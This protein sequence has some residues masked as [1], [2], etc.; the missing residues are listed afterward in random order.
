MI[1]RLARSL[2]AALPGLQGE[3][4]AEALWLAAKYPAAFG[5]STSPADVIGERTSQT[6][7]EALEAPADT[8]AET[9][10]NINLA[11]TDEERSPQESEAVSVTEVG[12][13]LLPANG[14]LQT[15]VTALSQFRRVRRPGPQV[16]DV[17]ATIE[18]TADAG[19]LVIVTG[20]SQERGLDVVIVVDRTPVAMVWTDTI[21]EFAA[22]LRRTG[23]F[24]SVACW[25]LDGLTLR[26]SAGT[27]HSSDFI[28]DP[29]GRRLVL[30]LTD[31]T[32]TWWY[33]DQPWHVL[34]RWAKAMPT[35]LVHL[36]PRS[37]WGY[38][39]T[40]QPSAT[41]RSHHPASPNSSAKVMTYWWSDD[42]GTAD[43]AVPIIT[44]SQDDIARWVDAVVSGSDWVD[45]VWVRPPEPIAAPGTKLSA[46]DQVSTFQ[47]RASVG[48]QHL[49]RILAGAPLL[50]LQ[51]IRALHDQLVPAPEVGQLAEI[52]VSGLLERLPEDPDSTTPLLRF[53]PGVADLLYKGT[54]ASQEWD[55]Y[56]MLTQH[57][58]RNART[59]N[60]IRA[61][62]ADPHGTRFIDGDLVPFAAMGRG[63]AI[64]LGIATPPDEVPTLRKATAVPVKP[65]DAKSAA[66]PVVRGTS[67][68]VC[69]PDATS[70][71]SAKQIADGIVRDLISGLLDVRDTDAARTIEDK[72]ISVALFVDLF[73]PNDVDQ[74]YTYFN[75]ADVRRAARERLEAVITDDTRVIVTNSFGA[76]VAYELL[77]AHPEWPLRTLVTFNAPLGSPPV[78]DRLD[79]SPR[80]SRNL[81]DRWPESITSWTNIMIRGD[82]AAAGYDL[83]ELF[84]GE[85]R[86]ILL[87]DVQPD[88]T[89]HLQSPRVASVIS[90]AL[91]S[92]QT[93]AASA[94]AR[95]SNSRRYLITCVVDYTTSSFPA[96]PHA[97]D[98]SAELVAFFRSLDYEHVS[99]APADQTRSR[100]LG[101]LHRFI[102]DPGRQP[103]D[104]VVF[105]LSGHA[106]VS[107]GKY[108]FFPADATPGQVDITGITADDL[109]NAL[110]ASSS[111]FMQLIVINTGSSAD[112]IRQMNKTAAKFHQTSNIA[113]IASSTPMEKS[114]EPG[115]T[116]AIIRAIQGGS[117]EAEAASLSGIVRRIN[118]YLS[119]YSTRP[120]TLIDNGSI[121]DYVF[122]F[123]SRQQ[124]ATTN[125]T[126]QMVDDEHH[127]KV[128]IAYDHVSPVHADEVHRLADL[129]RSSGVDAQFDQWAGNTRRDWYEWM[130][131]E[132]VDSDF[133]IVVSSPAAKFSQNQTAPTGQTRDT[134]AGVAQI[135]DLLIRDP[136]HWSSKILPVVLPSGSPSGFPSFINSHAVTHYVI[137]DFSRESIEPLLRII[138]SRP[139]VVDQQTTHRPNQSAEGVAERLA[140][141]DYGD[142]EFQRG[143][144]GIH[145]ELGNLAAT[146]GDTAAARMHYES[147][148]ETGGPDHPD[149]LVSRSSL[150]AAHEAAGDLARAIPLYEATL[151]DRERVLGTDHP[152]TLTERNNLAYAYQTA[153]DLTRAIPL[154]EAVLADR[155]RIL[156]PDHPSTLTSR[157]NLAYAYQTAGDL[158]R[159]IPLYEAVLADSERL[160]GFDHPTTRAIR[161]NLD[162][163]RST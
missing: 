125:T 8:P 109:S 146:A 122:A 143:S 20:A 100:I 153:G 81:H 61:V 91:R 46:A 32:S 55:I 116:R 21:D 128:F 76:V 79:P 67:G 148:L 80:R 136:Q 22:T 11:L 24:R 77:C 23:A 163:A 60:V 28:I 68:I 14:P 154:Y 86:T 131:R 74:M 16:V 118:R 35:T 84:G 83:R 95:R 96:L 36:L 144:S 70:S 101:D 17:D 58:E 98:E 149:T 117:D 97:A 25:S 157:N 38:T 129:L 48:A 133:I 50:S 43:V 63:M 147:T 42:P 152:D 139:D 115:F 110:F 65:T 120:A 39:A 73:S 31:A 41:V 161:S 140:A 26:D 132:V 15:T 111:R 87:N 112:A 155:E 151:A 124:A 62:L 103:E 49:A 105:Y 94:P 130:S 52:L 78:F 56:E 10:L 34:S 106:S 137:M 72:G 142:A 1:D 5:P 89:W 12:L 102:R 99:L 92:S 160:L 59:G 145:D 6:S 19:R 141:P 93:L 44:L 82:V 37:Y 9:S 4:L 134:Q 113:M 135:R 119:G 150:V 57:L 54:T 108:I 66:A 51:L 29:A 88:A 71:L 75:N 127:P 107:R 159:A 45:A 85:I 156:G 123:F 30:L 121:L 47:S 114:S 33:E 2:A 64:R 104:A 158:T 126:E 138:T 7:T 90:E 162:D 3:Q 40:G 69:V 13:R 27:A 18:A 53:R